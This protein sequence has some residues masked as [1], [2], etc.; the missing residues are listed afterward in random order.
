MMAE[1]ERPWRR[2]N[3]NYNEAQKSVSNQMDA[4]VISIR[5]NGE[6]Q[7]VPEDLNI[8]SLV[9]HLGLDPARVAVEMNRR[10]VRKPDWES[11]RVEPGASFEIVTFVGGG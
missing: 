7:Q 10:L 2:S 11:T 5:I 1:E 9:R 6:E 8:L 4:G 3:L